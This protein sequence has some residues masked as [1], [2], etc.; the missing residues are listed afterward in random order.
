MSVAASSKERAISLHLATTE[1][2]AAAM[3]VRS[4]EETNV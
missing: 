3:R 4:R 2:M 1:R